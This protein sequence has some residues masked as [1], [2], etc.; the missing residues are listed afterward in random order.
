MSWNICISEYNSVLN[1]LNKI[2][3]TLKSSP[4]AKET[5][6]LRYKEK[7]WMDVREQLD[8]QALITIALQR[9]EMD[10]RQ[11]DTFVSMLKDITGMD[12]V[13]KAII[14]GE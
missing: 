7:K 3:D 14:D 8:E 5:L 4:S 6:T 11:F 10:C 9:I 12:L 2:V 1:N 13:V